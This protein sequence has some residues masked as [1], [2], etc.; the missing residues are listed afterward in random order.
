MEEKDN[1][2]KKAIDDIFG[3][4][5]IEIN[6]DE[7]SG[8]T[9]KDESLNV[10]PLDD[11]YKNV[12]S[13]NKKEEIGEENHQDKN[14]NKK[15]LIYFVLGFIIGLILIYLIVNYVVG[16]QKVVNCFYEAEDVGYKVTDEYKIRYKNNSILYVDGT[17]SYT[18]KTEEYKPQIEY[19]KE[20]KVPIII[21]S[22]GMPGFT[23]LYETSDNFF[24]VQSYLDFTSFDYGKINKIDQ[25][26]T[27]ISYFK[28]D[29]N[30]NF[31]NLKKDLEN[32]GYVCTL[33]N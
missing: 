33:S 31:K 4:D 3:D 18:A 23:Y 25:K 21:N 13:G 22:N 8:E 28:I 1:D 12:L 30:L 11:D 9:N 17:Y 26:I 32:Q 24:K 5:V 27:P 14:F 7:K 19:V 20:E 6:Q 2:I 16:R 29:S 15:I 10:L